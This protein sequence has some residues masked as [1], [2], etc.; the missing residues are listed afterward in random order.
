MADKIP[1]P[2]ELGPI[3][4]GPR[5][6]HPMH[7]DD[8]WL[9]HHWYEAPREDPAWPEIYVYTDSISYAPGD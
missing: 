3:N 1:E 2:P 7:A 4:I 9:S 6:S 5:H 8:H